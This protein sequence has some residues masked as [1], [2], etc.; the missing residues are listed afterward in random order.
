MDINQNK[1]A[2]ELTA[3]PSVRRRVLYTH[4]AV[5]CAIC[6]V[7]QKNHIKLLELKVSLRHDASSL[8]PRSTSSAQKHYNKGIDEIG[9]TV[10]QVRFR[11]HKT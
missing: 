8:R 11:T 5:Y 6:Y 4:I 7:N 10:T 3:A 1:Y 2:H 9:A